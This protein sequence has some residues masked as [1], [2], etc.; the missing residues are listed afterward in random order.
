LIENRNGLVVDIELVV[1]SG[2]AERD[3]WL[4]AADARPERDAACF[5]EHE[6]IGPQCYRC[7]DGNG[8]L[9]IR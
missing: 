4:R 6:S 9:A 1:C 3:P 8:T 7:V 5:T 2:K